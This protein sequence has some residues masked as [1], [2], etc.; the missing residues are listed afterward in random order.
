MKNLVICILGIVFVMMFAITSKTFGADPVPKFQKTRMAQP[1]GV[2][3]LPGNI[4]IMPNDIS[5]PP[6]PTSQIRGLWQKVSGLLA[7][8]NNRLPQLDQEIYKLKNKVEECKNKTYSEADQKAAGCYDTQPLKEC[9]E[10][11]FFHCTSPEA[12]SALFS[13]QYISD[14]R[15]AIQHLVDEDI[16]NQVNLLYNAIGKMALKP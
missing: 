4:T 12:T 7:E 14:R 13:I 16:F 3:K 6:L 15:Y 8:V 9:Q 2:R 10:N 1:A 5:I 11:L